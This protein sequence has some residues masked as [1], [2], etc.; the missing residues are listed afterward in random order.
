TTSS[1]TPPKSTTPT[2][3]KLNF[4]KMKER[5]DCG[6]CYNCDEKFTPGHRCKSQTLYQLEVVE[7]V[8]PTEKMDHVQ[9]EEDNQLSI[10]LHAFMGT[11]KATTMHVTVII[12]RRPLRVLIDS[13]STHNF[14][15]FS[16]AEKMGLRKLNNHA[17]N[18][19]VANGETLHSHGQCSNVKLDIQSTSITLDF[20]YYP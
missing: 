12:A 8:E 17:V 18:V 2:I 20:F 13:G 14:L 15:A 3:H 11:P 5:R 19:M 9:N 6:L 4:A 10:S 16:I 7:E 1:P